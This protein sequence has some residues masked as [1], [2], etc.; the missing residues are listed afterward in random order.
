MADRQD[1]ILPVHDADPDTVRAL[2]TGEMGTQFRPLNPLSQGP[3]ALLRSA[4][5]GLVPRIPASMVERLT[6]DAAA[7]THGSPAAKGTAALYSGIIRALAIDG[8][9]LEEAISGE[10]RE[11]EH[12]AAVAEHDARAGPRVSARTHRRPDRGRRRQERRRRG[13][14]RQERSRPRSRPSGRALPRRSHLRSSWQPRSRM[15]R[16][17]AGR[18]PPASSPPPS[19]EGSSGRCTVRAPCL[20][21][22]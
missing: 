21:P 22:T 8:S 12:L 4:P 16:E 13:R 18:M 15:R 6:T 19:R 7:L 20:T 10:R 1:A 5:F 3:G 2:L 17:P 11:E 14:R 9:G